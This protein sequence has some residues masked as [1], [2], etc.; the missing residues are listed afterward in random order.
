VSAGPQNPCDPVLYEGTLKEYQA[1]TAKRST[2]VAAGT[3]TL[4]MTV[5]G[6]SKEKVILRTLS[7]ASVTEDPVP[8]NGIMVTSSGCGAA[9]DRHVFN[10]DLS[11]RPVEL[12]GA[13]EDT[14]TPGPT[15]ISRFPYNVGPDDPQDFL[16]HLHKLPQNKI[17]SFKLVLRWVADG[18]TGT[19]QQTYSVITGVPDSVKR[20]TRNM[21]DALVSAN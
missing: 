1:D 8:T 12:T 10:A 5:Q 21:Y 9:Q 20:Y 13:P 15:R 7:I 18:K 4:E 19:T 2:P 6:R 17:V 11:R 14:L 16:I 3:A